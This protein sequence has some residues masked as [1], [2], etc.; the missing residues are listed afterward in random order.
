ML[1]DACLNKCATHAP[2]SQALLFIIFL[3]L[4]LPLPPLLPLLHHNRPQEFQQYRCAAAVTTPALALLPPPAPLP[5][6]LR[7]RSWHKPAG[8]AARHIEAQSWASSSAGLQHVIWDTSTHSR[9][10]PGF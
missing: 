3:L 5:C 4:P 7:T 9:H 8:G 10:G 1:A 6:P 2:A